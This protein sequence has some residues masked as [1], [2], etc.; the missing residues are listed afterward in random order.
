[1]PVEIARC[2]CPIVSAL[3]GMGLRHWGEHQPHRPFWKETWSHITEAFEL[4]LYDNARALSQR[5]SKTK[6]SCVRYRTY[7][8]CGKYCNP[9]GA[10][11]KRLP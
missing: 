8:V 7:R 3:A 9:Q 11:L 1:M 4:S 10:S 6:A 2:Y 5:A